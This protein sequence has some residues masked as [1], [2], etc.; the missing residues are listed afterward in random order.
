MTITPAARHQLHQVLEAN[1][2]ADMADVLM[3]HLPPSGWTDVLRQHDLD[4]FREWVEHRFEQTDAR[5]DLM[6]ARF[7]AR[8]VSEIGA[9]G[10]EFRKELHQEV[11]GIRQELNNQTRSLNNQIRSLFLSISGLMLSICI[12]VFTAAKLL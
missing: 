8:L 2:G 12:V 3:E 7:D 11:G 10:D 1:I 4:R 6:E 9:L 5:F